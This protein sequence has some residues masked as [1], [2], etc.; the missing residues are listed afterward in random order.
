MN[1]LRYADAAQKC[2]VTRMTIRR[3]ATQPENAEMGFPKPIFLGANSVGFIQEEVD[4]WL[5]ARA[6]WSRG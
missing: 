6:T 2:G 3:W 5:A 4:A 1:I